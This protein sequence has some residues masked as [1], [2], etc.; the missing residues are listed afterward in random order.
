MCTNQ[1]ISL[2]LTGACW[3]ETDL[4]APSGEDVA[5]AAAAGLGDADGAGGAGGFTRAG[6]T[7]GG[8]SS[9]PGVTAGAIEVAVEVMKGGWEE[10]HTGGQTCRLDA[11]WRVGGWVGGGG[12]VEDKGAL[13]RGRLFIKVV[14][15]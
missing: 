15:D 3:C 4:G 6:G 10:G 8:A 11:T 5:A 13:F 7:G 14:E 2:S 12:G 1:G 9:D